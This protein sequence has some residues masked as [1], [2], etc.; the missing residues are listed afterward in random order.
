M[1]TLGMTLYEDNC[2]K[3]LE[4]KKLSANIEIPE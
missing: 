2:H 3:Y 1:Q 4:Q